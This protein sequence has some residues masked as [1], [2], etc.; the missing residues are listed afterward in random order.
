MLKAHNADKDILDDEIQSQDS[1]NVSSAKFK[2]GII[3][4]LL[5]D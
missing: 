1:V 3:S 5:R 4:N 2:N